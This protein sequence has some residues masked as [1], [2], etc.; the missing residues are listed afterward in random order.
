MSRLYTTDFVKVYIVFRDMQTGRFISS[1]AAAELRKTDP[2]RVRKE[3][4]LVL[5]KR[6]KGLSIKGRK[7]KPIS[8]KEFQ[9]IV[10]YVKKH[11]MALTLS[12]KT[13]ISFEEAKKRVKEAEQLYKKGLISDKEYGW[14]VGS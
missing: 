14:Y 3:T 13:G 11:N 10:Q 6:P 1:E 9:K 8:K 5:K 4:R 7:G 12:K 2:A